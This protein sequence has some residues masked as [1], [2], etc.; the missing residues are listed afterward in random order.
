MHLIEFPEQTTVKAKN[1]PE[2]NPLPAYRFV[3]DPQGRTVCCWILSFKERLKVLLSG[4]IWH[5]ILTFN[6]PLQPQL[7]E[8]DKPEMPTP[9][10]PPADGLCKCSGTRNVTQVGSW[11]HCQLKNGCHTTFII[12]VCEEC[13]G[14]C[15]FP[16]ENL[17]LALNEGT[18]QTK[19]ELQKI[20]KA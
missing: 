12:Q 14:I 2:Y 11:D 4:K 9:I 19:E 16:H 3:K 18:D 10:I 15:G 7:L 1:Q 8:V 20:L 13:K 5:Q 17:L 6:K